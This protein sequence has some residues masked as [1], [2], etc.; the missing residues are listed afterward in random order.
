[1][2]FLPGTA[3]GWF[4]RFPSCLVFSGICSSLIV[5]VVVLFLAWAVVCCAVSGFR[6]FYCLFIGLVGSGC[7]FT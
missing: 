7:L 6:V 5:D 1:M 3:V 4:F 2:Y